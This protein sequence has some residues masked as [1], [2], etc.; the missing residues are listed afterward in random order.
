MHPSARSESALVMKVGSWAPSHWQVIH[1][2]WKQAKN[3]PPHKHALDESLIPLIIA[4]YTLTEVTPTCA[5][6][7]MITSVFYR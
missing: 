2:R 7:V 1:D 3:R 5:E 6:D 4:C